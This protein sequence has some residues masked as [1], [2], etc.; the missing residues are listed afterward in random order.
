MSRKTAKNQNQDR[1]AGEAPPETSK[2]DTTV[3]VALIAQTAGI[4]IAIISCVSAVLVALLNSPLIPRLVP[5]TSTP[6]LVSETPV[7]TLIPLATAEIPF[8]ETTPPSTETPTQ[9]PTVEPA[10]STMTVILTASL[11]EGGSPLP[12][13]FN[14]R[15]T[16]VQFADGSVLA[17]GTTSFCTYTWAV[18]RNQKQVVAPFQGAGTFSYT[19]S[20]KG[21][22]SVTVYVCRTTIC[23][24]DGV[25]VTVK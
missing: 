10:A 19:F 4:V 14:A 22:Y 7:S 1:P 11:T 23:A 8:A 13:N 3:T 15:D 24:D 21:Q 2:K 18:Y 12:V 20:G 16:F 6:A 17:C 5:P 25:V 9:V